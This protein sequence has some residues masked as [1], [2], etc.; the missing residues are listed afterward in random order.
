MEQ[1]VFWFSVLHST[2]INF[3]WSFSSL[4]AVLCG[5]SRSFVVLCGPFRSFA[6]RFGSVLGPFCGP[7]CGPV[8]FISVLCVCL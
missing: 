3:V 4:Y 6:V 8:V 7:F 2:N 1:H 5:P